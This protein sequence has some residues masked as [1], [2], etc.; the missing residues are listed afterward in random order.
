MDKSKGALIR[1]GSYEINAVETSI[2]HEIEFLGG[3]SKFVKSGEK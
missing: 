2:K 1:C 3:I